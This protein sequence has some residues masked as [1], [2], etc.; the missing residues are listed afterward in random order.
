MFRRLYWE[1][2]KFRVACSPLLP[3]P[4]SHLGLRIRI[5]PGV[6]EAA[7]Y[8]P[9]AEPYA[10]LAY[11][12]SDFA[13]WSKPRYDRLLSAAAAYYRC[14][15]ARVLDLGCGT[16]LISRELAG[17]TGTVTGLDISDS[18]LA[19]ARLRTTEHNVHYLQGD[20]RR[21]R[22]GE[23]FDAVVCGGDSVNYIETPDELADVFRCV[24]EHLRPGGLF[25][26]DTLNHSRF[27]LMAHRSIQASLGESNF[28]IYFCYDPD[29]R[30]GEA[31]VVVG[32]TIERHRRIPLEKEDVLRASDVAR[33]VVKEHFSPNNYLPVPPGRQFYVLLR[34]PA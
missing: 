7:D 14:R 30:V 26:F 34:P 32:K 29:K 28:Q 22:L 13:G 5:V 4:P 2:T 3:T 25:L 20:F 21:F 12:Y 18:M 9:N 31:R 27:E 10:Q 6:K 11:H 15:V 24:H 8:E 33:L 16:G 19:Q 23:V 17:V 1:W